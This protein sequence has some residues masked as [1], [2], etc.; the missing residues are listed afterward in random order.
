MSGSRMIIFPI[1]NALGMTLDMPQYYATASTSMRA[2]N[3]SSFW[4]CDF[5]NLITTLE[6]GFWR[7]FIAS[8]FTVVST[9]KYVKL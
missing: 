1:E 4:K 5:V 8:T 7:L 9:A 6:Q 2:L 3:S